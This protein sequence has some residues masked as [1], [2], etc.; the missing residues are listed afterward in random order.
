MQR[1]DVFALARLGPV[2]EGQQ[3]GGD[4]GADADDE[5]PAAEDL[6]HGVFEEEAH[7]G[8]GNHGDEDVDGVLHA[9]VPLELEDVGENPYDLFPEDDDGA[10][11]RGHMDGN[12]EGEVLLTAEAKEMS[13]NGQVT[14]GA[15]GEIFGKTLDDAQD[16]R[17][18]PIHNLFLSFVHDGQNLDHKSYGD[19]DG[20][21]DKTT[22][23]EHGVVED[24][25][26]V[27]ATA[28][29]EKVA[30]SQHD[31]AGTHEDVVGETK[32]ELETRVFLFVADGSFFGERFLFHMF[33]NV[34]LFHRLTL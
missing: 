18:Q 23:V 30:D 32:S 9:L 16:K 6:F 1:R 13:S 27:A 25:G 8:D 5:E 4:H 10:E 15:D 3:G 19:E 33:M 34:F 29:E 26:V 17:L 31:K 22:V 12:G 24:I 28:T 21:H 2:A 11:H 7:D 20:R 14:A